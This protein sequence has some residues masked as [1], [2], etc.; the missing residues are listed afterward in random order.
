MLI[1]VPTPAK[2]QWFCDY[3]QRQRVPALNVF[4]LPGVCP[5]HCQKHSSH[6]MWRGGDDSLTHGTQGPHAFF[7]S[8]SALSL[9][10]SLSFSLSPSLPL[11][12]PLPLPFPLSLFPPPPLPLLFPLPPLLLP[13]L[14]LPPLLWTFF[15]LSLFTSPISSFLPQFLCLYATSYHF[16][17]LYAFAITIMVITRILHNLGVSSKRNWFS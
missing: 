14:T 8:E 7:L 16:L 6:I 10:V 15:S 5:E 12:S 2:T 4:P 3:S 13:L 11:P 9:S 17:C 1:S